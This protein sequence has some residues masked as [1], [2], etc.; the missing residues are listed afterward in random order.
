M[1]EEMD[2]EFFPF[3][4]LVFAIETFYYTYIFFLLQLTMQI[5]QKNQCLLISGDI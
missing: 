2:N 4:L 3:I 1:N 5:G